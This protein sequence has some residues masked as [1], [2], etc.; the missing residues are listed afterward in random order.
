MTDLLWVKVLFKL[1][2]YFIDCLIFKI[3]FRSSITKYKIGG[4]ENFNIGIK[5]EFVNLCEKVMQ[6]I[7]D[8][9]QFCE[10]ISMYY[11]VKDTN[12]SVLSDKNREICLQIIFITETLIDWLQIALDFEMVNSQKQLSYKIRHIKC[13][14]RLAELCCTSI[15]FIQLLWKQ[16]YYIHD[17]LL[18]LYN[19]EYMAISIK[20]M[21][22]LVLDIYLLHKETMEVFI[23]GHE[24]NKSSYIDKNRCFYLGQNGYRNL[25]E[26][27]RTNPTVRLKF[28]LQSILKKVNMFEILKNLHQAVKFYYNINES[29]ANYTGDIALVINL[30]HQILQMYRSGAFVISQPKRFI[31]VS[32]QFEINRADTSNAFLKLFNMYNLLDC[33]SLLLTLTETTIISSIKTPIFEILSELLLSNE[34]LNYLLDNVESVNVLLKCLL[35]NDE[36]IQYSLPYS[37]EYEGHTLGLKM[38]Y[39]LQCRYYIDCLFDIGEKYKF[40]CDAPEVTEQLHAFYCLTFSHVGKVS[41]SKVLSYNQNIKCLTQLLDILYIKDKTE[42]HL[43]KIKKSLGICYVIDLISLAITYNTNCAFIENNLKHLLQIINQKELFDIAITAKINDFEPYIRPFE[44]VSSLKYDNINPIV[45]IINKYLDSVTSY[46]G[47]LITCLRI[48]HELGISKYENKSS[49]VTENS[50]N[51]YVELKYKHVI[52]QLYSMDGVAILTKILQKICEHYDQ[53]SLHTTTFVSNQGVL[54]LHIIQPCVDLLKQM[55]TYVI[56]CRNT[57]FKDLT[58]IPVLLQTYNILRT[59][60][61]TCPT[62]LTVR[63]LCN[64]IIDALL[65]YTQPISEDV[66]E[67]ESLSKTLWTQM[68]GEV[69]KYIN[70]APYTFISGLLIFCELLPLPLPMQTRNLLTEKEIA[71]AIN[72]RKLWSAHLHPY[73]LNIQELINRLCTSTHAPLL[74]LLR[75]VC[76]QLSDLAA[77][78]AI[79]IAR[80]VLDTIYTGLMSDKEVIQ[81]CNSNNARLL[82]LLAC[83]VTHNSFKCAILHLLHPNNSNIS[84]CDEKYPTLIQ[85]FTKI[86]ILNSTVNSHVQAQECLLSIIQSLCD[87]EITLLQSLNEKHDV[88]P[89]MYLTNSLPCKENLTHFI[90]A[91]LDHLMSNNSFITYL[92]ILRTLLLLN[93]HDYGFYHLREHILKR[94]DLF[95]LLL[96]K[97]VDSFSKENEECLSIINTTME[98]LKQCIIPEELAEPLF[99]NLRTMKMS[100]D[101]VKTIIG[102]QSFDCAEDRRHPLFQLENLLKVNYLFLYTTIII[103]IKIIFN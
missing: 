79:M 103:I 80:G 98:F 68:C 73:S 41:C 27:M 14:V 17:V 38:S 9:N 82:N 29:G 16:N 52:I 25:I 20:Q 22:L 81:P 42:Q 74:N 78:S 63:K 32:S 84:K 76:I 72:L 62:Y 65:V 89:E 12:I 6:I 102:W 24:N 91:M 70:L 69:I 87:T 95:L 93:E 57:S 71:W 28:S 21:I 54:I 23:S 31:P 1:V 86:I 39:K 55:L 88:T 30:L 64:K 43:D 58:T 4:F 75:K 33:F 94:T 40:Y 66:N 15:E 34:G 13:G 90:N 10:I 49:I 2:F 96:N 53:P 45:E 101:E 97:L 48:L 11:I 36:A 60:P 18:S 44:I 59:F 26:I 92:P 8:T 67:K 85:S 99:A 37:V 50:L 77:N 46:P 56:Q 5:E 19:Q 83:L 51:N 7:G 61:V 3:Y 100:V 47:Q 35:H